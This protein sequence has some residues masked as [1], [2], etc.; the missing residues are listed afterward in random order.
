[1]NGDQRASHGDA[2][3]RCSQLRNSDEKTHYGPGVPR[4][5]VRRVECKRDWNTEEGY[6]PSL[7]K[8][9]SAVNQLA[10]WQLMDE[11]KGIGSLMGA[12][13]GFRSNPWCH[14]ADN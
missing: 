8:E 2:L 1:M 14:F 5:E 6:L 13:A 7:N 9:I 12:E 11:S 4:S 3:L 10:V